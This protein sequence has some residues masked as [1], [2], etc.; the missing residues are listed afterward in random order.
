MSRKR[1]ET[2]QEILRKAIV[3]FAKIGYNGTSMRTIANSVGISAAALYNHF[4]GKETLYQQ[5]LQQA[6]AEKSNSL[7][8]GLRDGGTAE[9]RLTGL[10]ECLCT[11]MNQDNDFTTIVIREIADSDGER[12][13]VMAEQVFFDI[14]QEIATLCA[15]LF[16]DLDS[17]LTAGSIVGLVIYPLASG[18]LYSH[19]N[20]PGKKAVDPAQLTSHII[21]LLFNGKKT[22][23]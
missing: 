11:M 8:T 7:L 23:T 4:P 18:K 10:I 16:P 20:G 15:E 1:S 17:H 3:L 12:L 5:A 9:H 21:S 13:K 6:F 19:L 22:D 2:K 14:H